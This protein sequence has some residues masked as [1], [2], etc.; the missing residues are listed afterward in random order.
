MAKR[1]S[2]GEGTIYLV[3]S[4][5]LWIAKITL[6][7]GKRKVKYA[8]TQKAVREWLVTQQNALRQGLLPK[9]DTTTVSE[10]LGNYMET[11]GKHTLRPKTIE[12]YLY[13]IRLHIVP[14]LG[15]IR[16]SQLRPDH[17][18]SLYAQKLEQGLSR[19]TVRFIHSVIHKALEQA[20]RWGL[21]VRNVA[22]LADPPPQQKRPPTIYTVEQITTLLKS[23]SDPKIRLAINLAAM[24]GFR[25]GEILGIHIEDINIKA[26]CI[27][28][29]HAVQ[30]QVGHGVVIT[31]PKTD[32]SR[33]TVKLPKRSVKEL[34]DYLKLINRNQGLLF[35][36]SSGRPINP[37]FLIKKFKDAIKDAGLPEIRFHD[38]RHSHSTLL[39]KAGVHP[40]LVQSRLG[41]ASVL[42]TL[43][44][45]SHTTPE[46]QDELV[47]KMEKV[48]THP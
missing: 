40:S 7:D 24:G 28:V 19:R 32:K 47:E 42:L 29:N 31:A 6:P 13:L 41:H 23:I 20:L 4:K 16:L 11:I 38:L 3:E 21:V 30:Y 18:Q 9:D 8:K 48:L 15:S 12:A 34:R 10:F 27:S 35:T 5:G 33:R 43:D 26:G 22:D 45:Y 36:T 39:L 25:E 2:K 1:R 37:R 17:L 14:N 46:M 44:T